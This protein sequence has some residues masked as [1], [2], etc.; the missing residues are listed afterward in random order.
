MVNLRALPA[1]GIRIIGI[2]DNRCNGGRASWSLVLLHPGSCLASQSL[3]HT[4]VL[5]LH[6]VPRSCLPLG[7]NGRLHIQKERPQLIPGF[8]VSM[9]LQG[10]SCSHLGATGLAK[11]LP[12]V[13]LV[14]NDAAA[15]SSADRSDL[16]GDC[17]VKDSVPESSV[18]SG[19][20]FVDV[21]IGFS[22]FFCG[23]FIVKKPFK[24]CCAL[25]IPFDSLLGFFAVGLLPV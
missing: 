13:F 6:C 16:A 19:F 24:L 18:C 23:V 15:S 12:Q 22:S 5:H 14:S 17:S 8:L 3:A 21:D 10:S 25:L 7:P 2:I 20:R 4:N 11:S 1:D 9:V